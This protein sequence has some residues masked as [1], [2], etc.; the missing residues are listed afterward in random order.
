MSDSKIIT[1]TE[2]QEKVVKSISKRIAVIAGPGSG[3]TRV[4]TERICHLVNDLGVKESEIL[5]LPYSTKAA[6]EVTLTV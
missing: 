3:K 2:N 4:F 5:A 6:K 1:L